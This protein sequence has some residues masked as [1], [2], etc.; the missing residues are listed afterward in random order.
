MEPMENSAPPAAV[1][2]I[3]RSLR[4]LSD[5]RVGAVGHRKHGLLV[6]QKLVI[7]MTT[8]KLAHCDD[9]GV[10]RCAKIV[11]ETVNLVS[12]TA[13]CTGLMYPIALAVSSLAL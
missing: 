10:S 6:E 3:T 7:R 1:S 13:R 2:K 5:S 9:H 8:C 11:V 12:N 4:T